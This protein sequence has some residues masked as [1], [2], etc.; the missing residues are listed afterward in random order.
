[1]TKY[2]KDLLD[3]IA[4]LY[5]HHTDNYTNTFLSEN[6]ELGLKTILSNTIKGARKAGITLSEI[7]QIFKGARHA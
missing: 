2:K 5:K 4:T 7:K 6:G 3:T 1:M